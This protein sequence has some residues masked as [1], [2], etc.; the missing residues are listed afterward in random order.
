[1]IPY[2][3]VEY[4]ARDGKRVILDR[5]IT[6]WTR[7]KRQRRA[8]RV[9][10]VMLS[11]VDR[12]VAVGSLMF[13]TEEEGIYYAKIRGSIAL[14]PRLCLGTKDPAKEVTF[15]QR[16]QEDNFDIIPRDADTRA[17]SRMQEVVSDDGKRLKIRFEDLA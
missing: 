14:R 16:A 3:Y 1:M 4:E 12:D 9:R 10:L 8:L 13:K 17:A 2:E 11:Q 7:E 15:L 5:V 6:D